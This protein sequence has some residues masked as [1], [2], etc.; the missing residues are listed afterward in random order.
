VSRGDVPDLTSA[1]KYAR[2]GIWQ[3]VLVVVMVFAATGMA[4]GIGVETVG[5]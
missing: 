2:I 4:R 3:T 1:P 5:E